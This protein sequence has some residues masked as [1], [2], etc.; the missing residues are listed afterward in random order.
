M[1][2]TGIFLKQHERLPSI[3]E[4]ATV[5]YSTGTIMTRMTRV[6]SESIVV[7][8]WYNFAQAATKISATQT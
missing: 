5:L 4:L 3:F 6:T 1:Y 7:P 8:A 2:P